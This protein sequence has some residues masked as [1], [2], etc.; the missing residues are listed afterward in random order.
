MNLDEG[1]ILEAL[2]AKDFQTAFNRMVDQYKEPLYWR[3]R[4]ILHFHE[5]SQ[6]VLQDAFVKIWKNLSKF[7]GDSA[8][9]SWAYRI[10]SNEALQ[11]LRSK[12]NQIHESIEDFEHR[13]END[14]YFDG[15]QGEIQFL[16]A[17]ESLPEKQKL[18]FKM[19][20]F[21][22]IKF[23]DIALELGLSE[24]GV[25][26]NYHHAVQKIKEIINPV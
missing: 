26:A 2:E 22:E 25:K 24:G 8:P 13:L 10:A 20:Y 12:K 15:D 21:N 3:I 23:K 6:D 9:Y 14:P 4:K 17:V 18:V 1:K 19:R 16:K 7:R 11:Y 5:E